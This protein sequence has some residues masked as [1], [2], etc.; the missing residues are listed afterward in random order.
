MAKD[1]S[2]RRLTRRSPLSD[3]PEHTLDGAARAVRV[4]RSEIFYGLTTGRPAALQPFR[5]ST[6][7]LTSL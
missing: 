1:G 5:P 6:M 2:G 4:G 7:T 3:G